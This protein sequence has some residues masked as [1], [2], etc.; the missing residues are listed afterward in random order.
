MF[1]AIGKVIKPEFEQVARE[2]QATCLDETEYN[3]ALD[4]KVRQ[5]IKKS[6]E[7]LPADALICS[8]AVRCF[9]ARFPKSFGWR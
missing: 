2:L 3:E 7:K 5:R 4:R 6:L 1:P 9:A 8:V